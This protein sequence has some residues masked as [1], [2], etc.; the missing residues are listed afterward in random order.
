MPNYWLLKTEPSTYSYA[1][2]VKEK[3]TVWNGVMNPVALRNIGLMK[4]GDLA[5]IYHTGDEKAVV[6]LAEIISDPYPDPKDKSL[7]IIDVKP[8]MKLQR[9]VTL[10]EIKAEKMFKDF[11]L[12][13][14]S[15][16][17]VM[18]VTKIWWDAINQM[19]ME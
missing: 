3:K 16:L 19:A 10:A 9:P 15:R 1:D 17:S 12:V 13:R 2:L 14:I 11:L 7:T 4:K 8:R 6:G 18:P 5:F